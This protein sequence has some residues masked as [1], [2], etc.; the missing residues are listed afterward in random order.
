MPVNPETTV[1]KM[2]SFKRPLWERIQDYR[3]SR[4]I[5]AETEAVRRLI[6]RGL[7]AEGDARPARGKREG[8]R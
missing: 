6:E 8:G 5:N 1:R 4:R 3:F 2:L 7:D